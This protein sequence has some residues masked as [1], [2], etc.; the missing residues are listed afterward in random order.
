MANNTIQLKRS[1]VAG[2]Q[3]NTSTLAVGELA[4]NLTDQK[5]YSSNGTGIFEPASNVSSLYVGNS[6]VSVTINSTSFNGTSNNALYLGG[7]LASGY[8]TTA[9]LS[10]N[11]STLSANNASFLGGV[12]AA[13]YVN[14]SGAYTITGVHTHNA[15]VIFGTTAG[16]SANGSIGTAGQILTS[17]GSSVYWASSLSGNVAASAVTTNT[18]SA[19][20]VSISTGTVTVGNSTVNT[21]VGNNYVSVGNSSG[22]VNIYSSYIYIGNTTANATINSTSYTGSANNAS[23]L[24]G[25]AA[26]NYVNTSGAYTIT[27]VHTHNA[28]IVVT[29]PFIANGGSGTS[30]QVLT[31]NG[32]TGAPYWSTVSGVNTAA[33]YT[34][35]NNQT[36]A[37]YVLIN[38]NQGL[39]FQTVNTS[40]YAFFNQQSDD[41]FVFYTT[42]TAYQPRPVWSIYANSVTSNLSILVP[43][44][45]N[46]NVYLGAVSAN[47]SLGTAGQLLTSNGT[48]TYWSSPGAA[49][50]N[51]AAQYTWTNT[52]TFSANI[53][54]GNNI[55]F[56]TNTAIYFNGIS[57]ANWK[58]GRNAG[59]LTKTY[60]T[61]NTLDVIGYSA[62]TGLEGIAFGQT[63]ANV[64]LETGYN[65][66]YTKNPIY[67]GNSTVNTTLN[68]TS[69]SGTS[70]NSLYLG[71]TA[72]AGYQTTAGLSAN[73]AT[74]TAN[75]TAF[76]GTVSAANVV[77]N[78]QL[79][80]NLASYQTT[81]GLN[82]NIA[83]YLPT[84]AGAVNA[85]AFTAGATGTGSGG[86]IANATT[87]FIGNNTTNTTANTTSLAIVN[88][89]GNL[90]I[91]TGSFAVSNASGNVQINPQLLRVS[92]TTANVFA[93]NTTS[94]SFGNNILVYANGSLGT[95]SQVLT[96]NGTSVYWSTVSGGGGGFTNGQS[97][98]VNN[99]V[100][101]GAMTAAGSNGTSGQ[102]LTSNGTGVYW[103]SSNPSYQAV[104]AQYT[105]NGTNTVFTVVGGYV[106]NN[107]N[108]YLNGVLLRKGTDYT[109]TD[110]STFTI[111]PAP[112]NGALIDV[113]GTSALLA[114]GTSTI[115]QQQFTAN[116]SANSF[117]IT[118]GYVPNQLLVFLNG[119]KQTPTDVSTSSGNTINFSVTPANNYVIDVYGYQSGFT[120]STN[121][122]SV[123]GTIAANNISLSGVMIE[124][125]TTVATDYTIT[126]GK[127]AM[128]AGPITIN[129]GITV[130]V[131][132]GSTWTIV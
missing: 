9:G 10:A 113:L 75:N 121:A 5:L 29:T 44:I 48:A 19:N 18:L 49:S 123:S 106:A 126:S 120:L 111:T 70:N 83:S 68:A 97:I 15:N 51:T 73:V 61:G 93:V 53:T 30:G 78:A 81:A 36:F 82:A 72:A 100:I 109:A 108:V 46:T 107:L 67:V 92:N 118:N 95:A 102:V 54:F 125:S 76:V 40:A 96:T 110:G 127:N 57:D 34:W 74:L 103:T 47:G 33:Q 58:I 2:K 66:T 14:T 4:L 104:Q 24:G 101:T 105:G 8:Q 43:T 59:G 20:Y 23:F 132:S 129:S 69:F 88:S 84:Y 63:G 27:G 117:Q 13:S 87:L 77:S 114:N 32:T 42:N 52:Q 99:F 122:I 21:D 130:T 28:N 65:G 7:T 131:P 1:S 64:Y 45:F 60:Y 38:N 37:S 26:A 98:S 12:A 50:V 3:P 56:P 17:N 79:T 89:T 119:V 91:T 94:I 71:G 85:S 11:V 55:A 124:N 62:V 16:I 116:G 31:S 86:V 22:Y 25:V 128:S 115:I 41:N 112:A 35:T 90:V 80:S 39:R 6:S